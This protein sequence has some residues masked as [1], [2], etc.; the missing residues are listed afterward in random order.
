MAALL[1]SLPIASRTLR[2][3]ALLSSIAQGKL[4]MSHRVDA[5]SFGKVLSAAQLRLLPAQAVL[6][7][8]AAMEHET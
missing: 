4:N 3:T 8:Q 5:L 7:A 6:L 1:Y 2:S